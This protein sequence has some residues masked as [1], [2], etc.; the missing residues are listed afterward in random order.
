MKERIKL[1]KANKTDDKATK[2]GQQKR[3]NQKDAV[4][5][6]KKKKPETDDQAEIDRE[7]EKKAKE[8]ED[9]RK[10]KEEEQRRKDFLLEARKAQAAERWSSTS[11]DATNF[12]PEPLRRASNPTATTPHTPVELRTP[13]EPTV[14]APHT[15]PSQLTDL[16]S[17]RTP[18]SGPTPGSSCRTPASSQTPNQATPSPHTEKPQARRRATTPQTS[19]TSRHGSDLR[20][21]RH[22]QRPVDDSSDDEHSEESDGDTDY[23]TRL[24]DEVRSCGSCCKEQNVENE[25]LR[26][27]LEKLHRRLNIACKSSSPVH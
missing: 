16:S 25:A 21:G 11:L 19:V 10:K 24:T 12:T 4:G 27:R 22:C 14:P 23:S 3:K 18:A 1:E 20:R 5:Q 9:K 2:E 13:A 8:K 26:Q 17:C 15:I 6:K 7:K